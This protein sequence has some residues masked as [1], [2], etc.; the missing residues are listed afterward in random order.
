M[1][2]RDLQIC[3]ASADVHLCYVNAGQDASL[4]AAST[5]F[6]T[7]CTVNQVVNWRQVGLHH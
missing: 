3:C 5:L 1:I 4:Q 6:D 7:Q 2:G